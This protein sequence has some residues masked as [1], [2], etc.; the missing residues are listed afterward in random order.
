M[1]SAGHFD[2]LRGKPSRTDTST[3]TEVNATNLGAIDAVLTGAW[4][5][6]FAQSEA[7]TPADLDQ[8]AASLQRQ[9]RDNGVT[10]NVYADEE[11]PQR[12]WSLDL[13]PLII[14]APSWSRIDEG[15]QQRMRLL[16]AVMADVYGPQNYLRAGLLPAALV[17]GH[18]GYLRPMHGARRDRRK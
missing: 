2:E 10:Y 14:D 9:I 12:P 11:G 4:S 16:E 1:A 7:Q 18:P 6:F 5:Q 8:R 15:V 3:A 13:F 17:Q